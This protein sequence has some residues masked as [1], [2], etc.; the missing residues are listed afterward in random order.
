V[1]SIAAVGIP[2]DTPENSAR[3]IEMVLKDG[4]ASI[5]ASFVREAETNGFF[6]SFTVDISRQGKNFRLFLQWV[7]SDLI[8]QARGTIGNGFISGGWTLELLPKDLVNYPCDPPFRWGLYPSDDD[9]YL[10]RDPQH[11]LDGPLLRKLLVDSLASPPPTL[12]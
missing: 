9:N 7:P 5:G 1:D 8:E 11:I 3:H 2:E 10:T 12:P 4:A 6:R